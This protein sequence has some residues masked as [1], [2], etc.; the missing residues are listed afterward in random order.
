M[1]A[2][3]CSYENRD[4]LFLLFEEAR[5]SVAMAV[6]DRNMDIA[7]SRCVPRNILLLFIFFQHVPVYVW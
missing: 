2:R 3:T 1:H 6:S 7:T 5:A 4:V